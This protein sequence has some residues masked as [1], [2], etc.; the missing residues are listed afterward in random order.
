MNAYLASHASVA[1]SFIVGPARFPVARMQK[2]SRWAD[3]KAN[4]LLAWSNKAKAAIKRD[5]QAA[6]PQ[7]EKDIAAWQSL[8]RDLSGNLATIIEIDA[9][10]KHWSRSAFANSIA[11]KIERLALSGEVALVDQAI[12]WLTKHNLE[13]GKVILTNR[14]KVWSFGDLARQRVA[15]REVALARGPELVASGEGVRVIV[16][17]QA[18]RVQIVFD[19]RPAANMIAKLKGEGWKWSPKVGVWQRKLTN[20]AK[21]SAKSITCLS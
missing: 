10:R 5:I 7:G 18:D 1:S 17:P 2:R 19:D 9:G 6:R 11:G 4:E 13:S 21:Y 8:R 15:Q 16:D 3:N 20:A 12:A 14:H